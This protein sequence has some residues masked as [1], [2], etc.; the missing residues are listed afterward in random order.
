MLRKG[1]ALETHFKKEPRVSLLNR[2]Y[3]MYQGM[4]GSGEG[5]LSY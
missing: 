2:M 1:N 3:R 4:C 5:K